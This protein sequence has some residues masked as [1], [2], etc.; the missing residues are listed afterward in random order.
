MKTN[1]N[2]LEIDLESISRHVSPFIDHLKNQSVLITGGTG[3]IGSCLVNT[4]VHLDTVFQLNARIAILSR[5]PERL[6]LKSP[7]LKSCNNIQLIASDIRSLQLPDKPFDYVIHAAGSPD[8]YLIKNEPLEV[9]DI[10][11]NGTKNLL[12][13]LKDSEIKNTLMIS[14]SLIHGSGQKY[15]K[16]LAENAQIA[17]NPYNSSG[18]YTEAKRASEFFS[19]V[20]ATLFAMNISVARCFHLIGP[21]IPLNSGN[22]MGDIVKSALHAT[23]LTI[24]ADRNTIRSYLYFSDFVVWLLKI[25]IKGNNQVYNVGSDKSFTLNEIVNQMKE[26]YSG[27]IVFKNQFPS[28]SSFGIIPDTS[29]ARTELDLKAK[30]TLDDAIER[31]IKWYQKMI[32]A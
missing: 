29:L 23:D 30:V 31:T 12:D 10:I 11:A 26:K 6:Y 13:V 1:A 3:F 9:Y 24:H 4:L 16:T 20:Y 5:N 21:F 7:G 17:S 14:S 32:S 2:L 15:E 25:L 18:S 22:L 27:N 28:P 8:L 19:S